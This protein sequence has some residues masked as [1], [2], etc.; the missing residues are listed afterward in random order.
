MVLVV[1][2]C[3]DTLYICIIVIQMEKAPLRKCIVRLL[4]T[5]LKL[6]ICCWLAKGWGGG[7]TF[8]TLEH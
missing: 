4:D 7:K 8:P 3:H 5:E 2:T 6:C 1:G